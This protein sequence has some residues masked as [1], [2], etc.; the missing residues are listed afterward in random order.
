MEHREERER[1][2][3]DAKDK[4]WRKL[5]CVRRKH[6]SAVLTDKTDVDRKDQEHYVNGTRN[7]AI[8]LKMTSSVVTERIS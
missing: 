6:N 1:T 2:G 7:K 4:I 5:V 3:F 8:Q